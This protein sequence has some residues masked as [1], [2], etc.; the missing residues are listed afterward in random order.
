MVVFF[1]I[2]APPIRNKLVWEL[3]RLG[4]G[5]DLTSAQRRLI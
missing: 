4:A 3:T 2:A 5:A 1:A